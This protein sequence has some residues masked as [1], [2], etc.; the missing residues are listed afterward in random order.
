M[1]DTNIIFAFG[2][3]IVAAVNPCGFAMLPAYIS[4]FLGLEGTDEEENRQ[5][6]LL[7]ALATGAIVSAGFLVVFGA[8]GI[9]VTAGVGGIRD[10][11]PWVMVV[12]GSGLVV[13]G[14]TMLRGFKLS[15]AL[16]QLQKGGDTRT[17]K[18]IFLFGLSYG[19]A[20]LS[21]A[22]PLFLVP[23]L[24]ADSFASGV[25]AFGAYGAGMSLSLIALTVSMG[26][27]RGALLGPLRKMMQYQDRIAG[28]FLMI[29]GAY[30][31]FFWL[32]DRLTDAGE[33]S[34]LTTWVERQSA[35][36][37]RWVSD[38]GGLQFGLR[39]VGLLALISVAVLLW[40][41]SKKAEDQTL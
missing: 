41:G 5:A 30:T 16:P 7:R 22:L 15:L 31:V 18:S 12:I 32:E 27:A 40:P 26:V 37:T 34:A 1:L 28:V 10:I 6:G 25:A 14:F 36:A 20:S 4:F 2:A 3:G 35:N 23:L 29:A 17:A 39:L 21:C 19:T 33:Q 11:I 13:L 8:V 38:I 9:L 24:A